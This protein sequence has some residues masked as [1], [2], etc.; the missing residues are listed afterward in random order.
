[1]SEIIDESSNASGFDSIETT[2][3]VKNE[4]IRRKD[5]SNRSKRYEAPVASES[6][7]RSSRRRIKTTRFDTDFLDNEEQRLLQHV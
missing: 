5:G 3:D 4:Q 2:D 6:E 7:Q 1:M